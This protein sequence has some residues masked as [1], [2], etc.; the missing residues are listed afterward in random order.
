[1]PV[2]A[3]RYLFAAFECARHCIHTLTENRPL[4]IKYVMELNSTGTRGYYR[5]MAT[6]ELGRMALFKEHNARKL[7]LK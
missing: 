6:S 2:L 4:I 7:N 5:E 3:A 1:M